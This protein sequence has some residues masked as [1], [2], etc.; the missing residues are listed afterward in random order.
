MRKKESII[1]EEDI[2][3]RKCRTKTPIDK[4]NEEVRV[5]TYS[6]KNPERPP[7]YKK[8]KRRIV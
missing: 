1:E 7:D 3:R 8:Q 6:S 4:Y 5:W 2:G